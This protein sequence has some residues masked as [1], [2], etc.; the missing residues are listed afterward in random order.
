MKTD[1]VR[2]WGYIGSGDTY[3]DLKITEGQCFAGFIAGV[4]VTDSSEYK[5]VGHIANALSFPYGVRYAVVKSITDENADEQTIIDEIKEKVLQ[6][7]LE[8]CRFIV[9]NG[10]VFGKY[11]K[12]VSSTVDLPVYMTSLMQLK[13]IKIGLKS[14]ENILILSELS[15][16]D[17]VEVFKHCGVDEDAYENC[18]FLQIDKETMDA[19]SVFEYLEKH[20]ILTENNVKAVLLDTEL[21]AGC[22]VKARLGV[23]VWNMHK[24]MGYVKKAVCQKP[25]HGFL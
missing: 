1:I 20:N 23:N 9:S 17:V 25:R 2:N 18:V 11:Q 10:G 8:G 14:T 13:W 6:L 24:L 5:P 4:L 3:G 16:D 7:E 21:F 12:I 22:D 19:E 15:S